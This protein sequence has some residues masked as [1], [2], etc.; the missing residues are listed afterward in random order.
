VKALRAGKVKQT[1]DLDQAIARVPKWMIGLGAVG[2][3][4][5]GRLG[6]V[7]YAGS[8]LAGSA[9]AWLNFRLIERFVNGLGSTAVAGRK[10][11]L[12]RTRLWMFIRFLFIAL[13]AFVILRFSKINIVV[14]LCGFLVCPAAVILEILY[15]LL[16]YG[17]S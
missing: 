6:G 7:L 11:P 3:C 15:E 4:V 5:A 17:H 9:A 2:S 10:R 12:T 1:M 13:G 8:F 14:A 16:T